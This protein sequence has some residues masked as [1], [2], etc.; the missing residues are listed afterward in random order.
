MKKLKVITILLLIGASVK[1]QFITND[2][3][4]ITNSASLTTNGEWHNAPGTN[5]INNGIIKTSE[6]FTNSGTLDASGTGGFVL[7]FSSDKNFLPGGS[8]MGFL[9]KDGAGSA[10]V[11]G[12]IAVKDSLVLRNGL[13]Q[14]FNATDTISV[15]AGALVVASPTSYV[16]GM[17][18][19]SGIGN[20]FFPI[21]RGSEY[22][23]L[24]MHKTSAK[25]LTAWVTLTPGTYTAGPGVDALIPFPYSWKVI[26]Q[27]NTDTA[28]YVEINYSNTLPV[29]A[30]PIVVREVSGQRFASMGARLISNA[31]GRVTVRS[32]SRGTKGL[33][34]IARGFPSDFKTDSLA[35]VSLYNAT[36]GSLTP[37]QGGWT[38]KTNWLTGDVDTW[39]GVTVTGQSI[40]AVNLSNNKLSG[41]VPDPLVDILSLQSVNLSSNAITEIPVF[42]ENPEIQSLNVTNNKLT[43]ESLEPNAGVLGLN[44]L[45][46][47]AFGT[48]RDESVPVGSSVSFEA[49]A[50]GSGSVYQWKRNGALVAG[51]TSP[52]YT[53]AAINKSNMGEYIAEVTNASLPGLILRSAPLKTLAHAD[54]NGKLYVSQTEPATAGTMLLYKVQNTKFEVVDTVMLANDGSYSFDNVILDDYQIRGFADT[55]VHARALPTYYES[56]IFWEEADTLFLENNVA[57]LDIF[58]ALEPL[59]P[60]GKGLISGTFEEDVPAGSGGRTK[61]PKPVRQAGVSA[62]RVQSTGRGQEE[63]LVLVAYVFTDENGQFTLPNLPTG[64]YRLNIQYPGYPMDPS[65]DITLVIGEGLQSQVTV[66]AKV[67]DGKINVKKRVITGLYDSEKFQVR[68]YPN[69]AIDYINLYFDEEAKGRTIDVTSISGKRIINELAEGKQAQVNVQPLQRGI[70]LLRV[71]QDGITVKT[72]KVV[73]E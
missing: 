13:I 18:A 22:L 9:T 3:I 19:R 35:L 4:A 50:G 71:K 16:E 17:V 12:T 7:Q 54:V 1:A 48:S 41:V 31:A 72:L 61:L 15:R 5:I 64:T 37:A 34:T 55:L 28:A 53:V 40:T 51:A 60:S 14:M 56:T 2:G 57:N 27:V 30:N 39:F 23:P 70:Y 66:D 24:T 63:V 62:R 49:N 68:L 65:S 42:T 47:A 45:T 11:M 6:T 26:E 36:G 58:S 20:L 44:Y 21:G 59:P 43:F 52:V 32:Y 33:F 38:T 10:V 8:S 73:L 67:Q 69:P 25:K 46:Q 29:V